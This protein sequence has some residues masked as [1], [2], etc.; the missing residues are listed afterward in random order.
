[1]ILIF[2]LGFGQDVV[3]RLDGARGLIGRKGVRVCKPLTPR[4]VEAK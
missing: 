1:M 3:A 4:L 2:D